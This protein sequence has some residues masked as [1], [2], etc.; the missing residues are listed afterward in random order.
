MKGNLWRITGRGKIH[1]RDCY[2]FTTTVADVYRTWFIPVD[3][4]WGK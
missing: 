3:A 2:M 1:G 4:F